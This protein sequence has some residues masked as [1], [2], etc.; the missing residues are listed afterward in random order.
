MFLIITLA[1]LMK[2]MG[3]VNPFALAIVA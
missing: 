2:F 3:S 1:I